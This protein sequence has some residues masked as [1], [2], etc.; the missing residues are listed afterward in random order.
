MRE[1]RMRLGLRLRAFGTALAI[2]VLGAAAA[3]SPAIALPTN[4]WGVVPQTTP[5]PEQFQRLKAGGVD[6]VR[7]AISWGG[8]QSSP[9]GPF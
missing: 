9:G 3:A 7:I 8:V 4:F 6:S 1:E 2:V 5:S